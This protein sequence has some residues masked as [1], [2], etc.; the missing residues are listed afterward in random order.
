MKFFTCLA[1]MFCSIFILNNFIVEKEIA[2]A[3]TTIEVEQNETEEYSANFVNNQ[4]IVILDEKNSKLN[5][6][7]DF[8]F[9]EGLEIDK[10]VNLTPRKKIGNHEKHYRIILLITLKNKGKKHVIEAIKHLQKING[11]EN[12]GPNYILSIDF[13]K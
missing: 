2:A 10:I 7:P 13:G 11:I 3:E 12:A 6:I 8:N 9:F 4:V 5:K 1:L